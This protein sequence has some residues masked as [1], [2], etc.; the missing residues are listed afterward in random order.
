MRRLHLGVILGRHA[1]AA[2]TNAHKVA[3]APVSRG[4]AYR[5]SPKEA[6]RLTNCQPSS[7]PHA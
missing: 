2:K 6:L 7:I 5:T 3:A 1:A 4:R